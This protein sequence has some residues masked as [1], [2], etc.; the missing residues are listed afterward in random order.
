MPG[1]TTRYRSVALV[2][3]GI[4]IVVLGILV[5]IGLVTGDDTGELDPQN[6]E[7]VLL[8]R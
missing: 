7:I 6:G 8:L 2:V 3:L 1:Q 4:V 5:V